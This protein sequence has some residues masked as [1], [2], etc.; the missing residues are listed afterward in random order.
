MTASTGN[1]VASSLAATATVA[2]IFM[3]S[4]FALAGP[5]SNA[6]NGKLFAQKLV[7]STQ[8]KHPEAD[9]IGISTMTK[10]GCV[11][12]ASTDKGDIGEKCEKDDMEPMN[13][14]KPFV[15]KERDGF[16]VSLPLHDAKGKL[17]GTVGIGFKPAPGQTEASV[18]REAQKIASEM[19]AQIPSKAALFGRS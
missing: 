4:P 15:E 19:E 14:G 10:R 2:V 1:R 11:G 13:T 12:I 7:E 6:Q 9:E 5:Q 16:D 3:A 17:I 8:A 18:T